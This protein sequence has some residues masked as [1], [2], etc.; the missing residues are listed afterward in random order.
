MSKR[1]GVAKQLVA[2]Q[3][4][5]CCMEWFKGCQKCS[6][7]LW[8][9]VITD[10]RGEESTEEERPLTRPG[11]GWKDNIKMELKYKDV[12]SQNSLSWLNL[13]TYGMAL[14]NVVMK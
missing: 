6:W 1:L 3:V 11:R 7:Q 9:K 4:W 5:L 14:V 2:L 13:Q 10:L 12:N 8:R